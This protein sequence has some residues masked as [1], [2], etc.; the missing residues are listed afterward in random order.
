MPPILRNILAVIAGVLI[1]S[2]INMAIITLGP[3][4]IPPPEG[5]DMSDMEKFAENLKLLAPVN[6]IALGWL[7]PWARWS[8]HLLRRSWQQ[9]TR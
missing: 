2:V 9:V 6:F 5:V 3:M 7:M 8:E 1:G 4:V